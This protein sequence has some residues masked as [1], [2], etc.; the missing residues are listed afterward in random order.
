MIR[1]LNC[2]LPGGDAGGGGGVG[3]LPAKLNTGNFDFSFIVIFLFTHSLESVVNF[4]S[5]GSHLRE[6][7]IIFISVM[8]L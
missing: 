8:P 7:F 2:C 1:F 6:V 4:S 5:L 3:H